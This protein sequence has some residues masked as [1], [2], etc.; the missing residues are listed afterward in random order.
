MTF[1]SNMWSVLCFK[2]L[3]TTYAES[4]CFVGPTTAVFDEWAVCKDPQLP[5]G[6]DKQV[7][8]SQA[9]C[10][11]AASIRRRCRVHGRGRRLAG[12]LAGLSGG[13]REAKVC[14]GG[15]GH[16][17]L[18]S[19]SRDKGAPTF[20]TCWRVDRRQVVITSCPGNVGEA[21]IWADLFTY[22]LVF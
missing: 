3:W 16:M 7:A 9:S 13:A 14:T 19:I 8:S 17:T 21:V 11:P 10:R 15:G 6:R 12:L 20:V 5:G 18:T 1:N 22:F 4:R 2:R